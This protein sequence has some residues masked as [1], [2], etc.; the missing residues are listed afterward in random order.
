[1]TAVSIILLVLIALWSL[2]GYIFHLA[3]SDSTGHCTW[4]LANQLHY[5][6]VWLYVYPRRFIQ[7]WS[8]LWVSF[9]KKHFTMSKEVR[10]S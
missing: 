9:R 8:D 6:W 7:R 4:L 3:T 1:V 5:G 2:P 10:K